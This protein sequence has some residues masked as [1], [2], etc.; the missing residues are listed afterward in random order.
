MGN[1]KKLSGYLN[2]A[3]FFLDMTDKFLL[4]NIEFL[5]QKNNLINNFLRE[6]DYECDSIKNNL[7][8]VDICSIFCDI[9]SVTD[10]SFLN[11]FQYIISHGILKFDSNSPSF[12]QKCGFK[13][14]ININR[15][16]NYSDIVCLTHEFFHYTNAH[17]YL[18]LTYNRY[19]LT[20]FI[21]IYFELFS[22]RYLVNN[23]INKNEILYA[24]RLKNTC[25]NSIFMSSYDWFLTSL[26]KYNTLDYNFINNYLYH[27]SFECYNYDVYSLLSYFDYYHSEGKDIDDIVREGFSDD[28]RYIFGT[29]LAFYALDNCDVKSILYLNKN[30]N[31]YLG[32]LDIFDVLRMIGINLDSD[33]FNKCFF[34]IKN[35][36][37]EF[38]IK[39]KGMR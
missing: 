32:T 35:Y 3:L 16:F 2:Q 36:N 20:E 17:G 4:N 25:D 12:Y 10:N 21:S 24:D 9:L 26:Y 38:G 15:N 39:L 29:M 5:S 7:S 8:F 28:Y 13:D 31:G 11:D 22:I 18:E 6:Y 23:G 19:L 34:S 30:I 33:F 37:E 14:V 27:L 1:I